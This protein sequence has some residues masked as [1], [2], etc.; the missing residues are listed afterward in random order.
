MSTSSPSEKDSKTS[1]IFSGHAGQNVVQVRDIEGGIHFYS[2]TANS[3]PRQIPLDIAN[4]TGRIEDER[5]L[6]SLLANETSE[7]VRSALISAISGTAG[8]GKT[9]LAI[10]WAHRVRDAF[11]DG[12]LYLDLHGYDFASPT[13]PSQALTH[14]LLAL[15]TRP[16]DIPPD[17]DSKAALYRTLLHRKKLLIILDNAASAEQVRSLLPASVSCFTLITSRSRLAGLTT[18]YPVERLSLD[19]LSREEAL[20]LLRRIL[21]SE[22]VEVELPQAERLVELCVRL[23]LALRIV[24]ERLVTSPATLAQVVTELETSASLLDDLSIL[25]DDRLAVRVVFDWSYSVLSSTQALTFRR[26]G[27]HAGADISR[28]A[29]SAL[30]LLDPRTTQQCL[31]RLLSINLLEQKTSGRYSFHD[32]L[33]IYAKE[34]CVQDDLEAQSHEATHRL[35]LWYLHCAEL[36]SHQLMPQRTA[37]SLTSLPSEIALPPLG[38]YSD[39]IDWCEAERP[40]LRLAVVQAHEHGFHD[41]AWQ[42]A[43]ALRGF[44]NIRKHWDDWLA[45]HRVA[46]QSAEIVGDSY[47][48]GRVLNGLG[49]AMRQMGRSGEAIE[50]H[51]QALDLRKQLGDV[52]GETSALDSLGN[53]YRDDH[54][55]ES[56]IECY[57]TSLALREELGDEHGLAW[58]LNNLG[59]VLHEIDRSLDALPLLLEALNLRRSVQDQWGE[60]R[61]LHSLAVVHLS[62]G[63]SSDGERLLQ[64]AIAIRR[65]IRDRWGIAISLDACG[66]H[67]Q[68]QNRLDL[69]ER[70]WTESLQLF[71]EIQDPLADYVRSRLANLRSA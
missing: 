28:L 50:Y 5:V 6:D 15:G 4:F 7:S 66:A 10:H 24:A 36:A 35:L 67:Y 51:K 18:T 13:T 23:P 29:V 38:T 9:A 47:A 22:R 33:R 45:T 59:E 41:L 25:E 1:N 8:V 31:D 48:K 69:A 56:A 11:P 37:L 64:E 63:N 30:A 60:G 62:L 16:A 34:R 32:L 12:D 43:V 26:I 55:V 49:T 2:A 14:F 54:Q 71:E 44:F 20:E 21:G 42:I 19:L 53:A 52:R 68:G 27:L 57:Q 46:L 39:A 17:D 65:T 40:N 61:T 70:S 3:A 58:S